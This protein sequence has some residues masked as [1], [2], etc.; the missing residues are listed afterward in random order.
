MQ[1]HREVER[2]SLYCWNWPATASAIGASLSPQLADANEPPYDDGALCRNFRY[3]G[4]IHGLHLDL[5]LT[6]GCPGND[7]SAPAKLIPSG[8]GYLFP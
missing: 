6:V 1:A 3:M 2:L 8:T 5:W 7:E 4:Q